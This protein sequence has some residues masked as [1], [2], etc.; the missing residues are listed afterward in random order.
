MSCGCLQKEWTASGRAFFTHKKT[1]SP[2]YRTWQTMKARCSNK[3]HKDFDRYGGRGISFCKK[4]EKFE[5]F[6][7]DMGNRPKSK[8]LDRIDNDGMYSKENCRW[9]TRKEQNRNKATNVMI[10]YKGETRCIA[11]WAE[12]LNISKWKLY[13]RAK[14]SD[15]TNYIF[16]K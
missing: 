5:G 14:I 4:W 3:K 11:E 9:A 10:K 16:K 2:E 12:V 13:K 1:G 8:E 6:Y 15:D 7:E